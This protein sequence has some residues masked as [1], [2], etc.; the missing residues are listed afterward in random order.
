MLV[1]GTAIHVAALAVVVGA[2]VLWSRLAVPWI[3]HRSVGESLAWGA[4]AGAAIV[5]ASWAMTRWCE[6]GRRLERMLAPAVSGMPWP[7]AM[8]L[9]VGAGVA[10]EA[11]FRGALWTL[12]ASWWGD[13]AAW[14][15]TTALFGVVHGLFVRR[16]RA[17]GLFALAAGA[18]LGALRWG[19]GGIL[20]PVAAHVVIDAIN[21]PVLARRGSATARDEARHAEED[22]P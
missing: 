5:A 20:A 9:A 10:E 3:G 18:V 17:W 2:G 12:I 21:L 16:L 4:L 15:V 7:Q 6:V 14:G 22:Q 1:V 19:T 13:S 11:V 8:V